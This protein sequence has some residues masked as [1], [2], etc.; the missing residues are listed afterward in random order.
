LEFC[1]F[2]NE[3]WLGSQT[4]RQPGVLKRRRG[5]CGRQKE[6]AAHVGAG[7]GS[8]IIQKC[9]FTWVL[10]SVLIWVLAVLGFELRSLCLLDRYLTSTLQLFF[11]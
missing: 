9:C 6:A 2:S 4:H 3:R 11:R 8:V 1:S 5:E 10:V 7:K